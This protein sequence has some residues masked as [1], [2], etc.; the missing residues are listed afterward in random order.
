MIAQRLFRL[1]AMLWVG[2][3]VSIG[4]V[5]APTLFASL[6]RASAGT[7][8]ASLFHTQAMIGVVAGIVLLG[9]AHAFVKRGDRTYRA[10]RWVI[11]AMLV[12]V[13]V[14][15]FALQP[16]MNELRVAAQHAGTDVGHSV[17]AARFGALHVASSALYL[18]Q[19]LLG[20]V[21]VWRLPVATRSM[22]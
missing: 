9:F 21:L 19:S 11:V 15:Y 1:L 14:G 12:C 18:V 7:V 16:F 13:L 6:D 10:A 8:A 17:Y 22:F 20:L 5:A 2:S 3:L 4:Y